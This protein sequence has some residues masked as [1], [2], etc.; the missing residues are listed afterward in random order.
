M[1]MEMVVETVN[2]SG[3][4]SSSTQT[5][6]TSINSTEQLSYMINGVLTLILTVFTIILNVS[7]LFFH[8]II[9]ILS[10]SPTSLNT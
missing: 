6:L 4:N 9:S 2:K 1:E 3:V 8:L 10:F 5:M 7:M